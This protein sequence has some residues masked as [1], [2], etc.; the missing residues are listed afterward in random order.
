MVDALQV[1]RFSLRDLWEEFVL[2]VL[3][4]MLWAGAVLLPLV[5]WLVLS[6]IAWVWMVVLSLILSLPLPIVSG[7]LAHVTNQIS[8]QKSVGWHTFAAGIRRYWAKSLAVAAVNIIVLLLVASNIRFYGG[9]LEGTWTN[10][11]VAI[12][13]VLAIYWLLVQVFWFPMLLE[14]ENE[15]ILLA[16]RNALAMALIT[17]GFTLALGLIMLILSILCVVLTVP[18][19]LFMASLLL[20]MANHA[21][22]SRLAHVRK[23]SY[24]PGLGDEQK[25]A[26]G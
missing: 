4:N 10:F 20:L 18:I 26:R 2:L 16:L 22:R 19:M 17:P 15:N 24:R 13:L 21:T 3:M 6:G 12:W 5:P 9:V 1:V 25:E 8:R 7:A 23:E 14:L 11:A